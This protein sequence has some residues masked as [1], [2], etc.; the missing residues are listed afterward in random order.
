M[1]CSP[2]V[3]IDV[4]LPA[5]GA[6]RQIAPLLFIPLVENAFKHGISPSEPSAIKVDL[7][8]DGDYVVCLVENTAFPKDDSD[9]SGSGIGIK[10]LCRRLDMLYPGSYAFEYGKTRNLYRALLKINT[11]QTIPG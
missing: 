6:D 1:R 5:P 2:D 7:R 3:K 9:R 10:N 11:T 4:T 8:E